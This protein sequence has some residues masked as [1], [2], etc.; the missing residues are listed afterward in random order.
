MN[1]EEN[2]VLGD[3]M[4]SIVDRVLECDSPESI[5]A[6]LK[7]V[8]TETITETINACAEVCK[9]RSESF[10]S[11]NLKEGG[12]AILFK[13]EAMACELEIRKLIK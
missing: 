7:F 10:N 1:S 11:I 13:E 5:K 9:K 6:Y 2:A 12:T 3:V 4:D 8:I